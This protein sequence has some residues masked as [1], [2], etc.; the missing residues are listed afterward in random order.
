VIIE[1]D[2]QPAESATAAL[3]VLQGIMERLIKHDLS[4][5]LAREDEARRLALILQGSLR[6]QRR[7]SLRSSWVT[8]LMRHDSIELST[9][10]NVV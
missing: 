2:R 1:P 8:S 4:G 6:R 9:L 3:F 7:I 10:S 5:V